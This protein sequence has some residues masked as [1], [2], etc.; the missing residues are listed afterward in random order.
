MVSPVCAIA[1]TEGIAACASLAPRMPKSAPGIITTLAGIGL[2]ATA[3]ACKLAPFETPPSFVEQSRRE[4]ALALAALARRHEASFVAGNYY[5]VWPAIFETIRASQSAHDP[6]ALN[7]RGLA[8]K[9]EH[10]RNEIASELRS[11]DRVVVLAAD[12]NPL[13]CYNQALVNDAADWPPHASLV[14]QGTLPSGKPYCVMAWERAPS[15]PSATPLPPQ[16]S[17]LFHMLKPVPSVAE[18]SGDRIVVPAG[19]PPRRA[20]KGP[21]VN[22]PPGNYEIGIRIEAH[23][24]AEAPL[25]QFMIIDGFGRRNYFWKNIHFGDLEPRGD[26]LWVSTTLVIPESS[27]TQG[28][29]IGVWTFGA[30]P[31][32][33]TAAELRRK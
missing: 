10:Q 6:N 20:I 30:V 17:V 16:S 9:G 5:L 19:G 28:L 27:P 25:F 33:I 1:I 24:G 4:D 32:S 13:G 14:A 18:W 22:V 12:T 31:F 3:V 26:G 8:P 15:S 29:E 2:A 21:M 23:A 7:I 11:S